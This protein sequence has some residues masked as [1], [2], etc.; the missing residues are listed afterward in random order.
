ALPAE[1][2]RDDGG[3]LPSATLV[4]EMSCASVP[5]RAYIVGT[6]SRRSVCLPEAAHRRALYTPASVRRRCPVY[7]S[8]AVSPLSTSFP[9]HERSSVLRGFSQA[10]SSAVPFPD[11]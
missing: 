6:I 2:D 10:S 5:R 8:R 7:D 3:S 1:G 9:C 4:E 11:V